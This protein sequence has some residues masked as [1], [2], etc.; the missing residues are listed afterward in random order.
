MDDGENCISV[1][2]NRQSSE[3]FIQKSMEEL[4]EELNKTNKASFIKELRT[5]LLGFTVNLKG[6]SI[7]DQQGAMFLAEELEVE[8][9]DP[10]SY[11]MEIK[12][13]WGI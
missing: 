5:K 12:T 10:K 1:I 11:A 9:K 7:V 4:S 13:K 6:R 8:E 3:K 2:M